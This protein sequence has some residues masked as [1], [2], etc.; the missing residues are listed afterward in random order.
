[1]KITGPAIRLAA[2]LVAAAITAVFLDLV[3]SGSRGGTEISK[4]L[5]PTPE[6]EDLSKG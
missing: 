3:L 6:N 2:F 1:M 4:T 5:S